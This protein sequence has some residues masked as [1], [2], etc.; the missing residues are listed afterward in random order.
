MLGLC[1]DEFNETGHWPPQLYVRESARM[2]SSVVLTQQ[3]VNG[4][5]AAR[6]D[7]GLGRWNT[8]VGLSSWGVDI[9]A[10]RRVVI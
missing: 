4:A 7:G 5:A 2:V 10:Q 8:S 3:D 6:G 9:H 1:A